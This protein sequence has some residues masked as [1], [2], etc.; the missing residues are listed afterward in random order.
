M[1]REPLPWPE[2]RQV[3]QTAEDM[4]YEAVFVPEIA[5]R[6]AFVTL[7][8]AGAETSR[9]RL[10]T[11]VVTIGARSAA[12]TA[13]AASTVQDLSAGRL[14]LGIGSGSP[15]SGE[16]PAALL[17][18]VRRYVEVV[19]KTLA[20]EEAGPVDPSGGE[21]FRL[22]R[23]PD[24][25]PPIWLGALGDRMVALAAREAD[26][27]LL[28]WCT[29]ERVRR[30][31]RT[32]EEAAERSGRA[33]SDVTVAVYV[34]ACLGLDEERAL[35]PLREMTGRYAALPHYLAQLEAMGLGEEGRLAARAFAEGRPAAVPGS[36]V[37][38]L[39][40][41]GGRDEALARFAEYREAGADLVLCYPVAALDPF[42]SIL[43]TVHA[44]APSPTIER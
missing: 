37:R 31:R 36:L 39:A 34:R 15:R 4:G 17:G 10:G 41:V 11:G 30:A 25:P 3:V 16:A 9:L 42:S 19:R 29:P 5:G 8:A 24:R 44:A 6:E 32:I 12:T 20:G 33:P 21:R 27:V 38:A 26:G 2:C 14:I 28:N 23:P 43:G 22:W 18:R 40:V 13:M 7:A 35:A 1:L